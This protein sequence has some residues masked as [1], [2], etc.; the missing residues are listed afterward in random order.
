MAEAHRRPTGR[1]SLAR[2]AEIGDSIVTVTMDLLAEHGIDF[3]M[4]QVA[5]T[6]GISKQAIYR[7]WPSKTDLVA[8]VI[9]RHLSLLLKYVQEDLPTDPM[10]ALRE[11]AWRIF[12]HDT[13][14]AIRL[15]VFLQVEGLHNEPLRQRCLSWGE[16]RRSVI[17]DHMAAACR[18]LD[19]RDVTRLTD[20]LQDLLVGVRTRAS[21]EGNERINPEKRFATCWDLF[22][23][24]LQPQMASH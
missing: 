4:D 6:A 12:E 7:R 24:L 10:A 20:L 3:S 19:P 14:F 1:P 13:K 8:H 9:D 22:E 11:V 21:W 16:L 23:A 18:H 2:A 15:M 5:A 17:R